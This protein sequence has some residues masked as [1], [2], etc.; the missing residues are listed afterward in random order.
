MPGVRVAVVGAGGKVGREV[1]RTVLARDDL[2]LVAAVDP[3]FE[4]GDL[5]GL[6]GIAGDGPGR[7][8]AVAGDAAVLASSGTEVAV[9]FT[10]LDAARATL[11][12]CADHGIHAVVGTTG[13]TPEDLDHLAARFSGP[14]SGAPNCVVAPNFAIGAVLMMRFAELAAPWFDAAEIVEMHH[15]DQARR[16]FGDGDAHGGADGRG[17]PPARPRA[18]PART[19]RPCPP[20]PGPGAARRPAACASTRSGC[21]GWSPIRRSSSGPPARR[22]TIRHDSYDRSSFMDGVLLAVREVPVRP[23]LTIGIEPLLGL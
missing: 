8:T 6:L 14:D 5:A 4:G 18:V 12:F 19:A 22:L 11:E 2:D 23:G 20:C 3:A 9:D 21:P 16:P 10:R 17:P 7:R 1:C 13:F 15:D